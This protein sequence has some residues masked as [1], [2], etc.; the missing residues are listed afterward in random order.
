MKKTIM[1]LAMLAIPFA[2]QAQTKFHDVEANILYV[3]HGYD[4]ETAYKQ[5][6]PIHGFHSING[7]LP[8]TAVTFKIRHTPEYIPATLE[9]TGE[10]AYMV[11]SSKPIHG[12]QK[13]EETVRVSQ[14]HPNPSV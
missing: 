4:P 11:H 14:P 10:G 5:T 8:P 12:D 9:K 13:C 7:V 1:M 2:I 3:S 6:F